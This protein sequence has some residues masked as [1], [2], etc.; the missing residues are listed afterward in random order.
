M[1][2]LDRNP[3]TRPET[4][5][6]LA[7]LVPET[8]G[9]KTRYVLPEHEVQQEG[10]SAGDSEE[11]LVVDP[12][13]QFSPAQLVEKKLLHLLDGRTVPYSQLLLSSLPRH[14]GRS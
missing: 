14:A 4:E 11:L 2:L 10:Q 9:T 6:E 12:R 1:R 8:A 3:E 7:P 5:R 13:A